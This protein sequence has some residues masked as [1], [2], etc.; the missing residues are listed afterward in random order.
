MEESSK[1]KVRPLTLVLIVA[2]VLAVLAAA[3][4]FTVFRVNQ[5]SLELVLTAEPKMLLE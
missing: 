3:A 1:K 2:A 4:W 5:F